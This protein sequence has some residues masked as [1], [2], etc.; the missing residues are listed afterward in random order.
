MSDEPAHP[1]HRQATPRNWNS[2]WY[3][4]RQDIVRTHTGATISYTYQDHPGAVLVVPVTPDRQVVLLRQYRYLTGGW[5]WEAPAGGMHA[6]ETAANCAAREL[7]EETGY[8]AARIDLLTSVY[9]SKSVSNERLD[10]FLAT[11]VTP[12]PGALRHEPSELMSVVVL[13]L[14]EAVGLV[15]QHQIADMQTALALLLAAARLE[16]GEPAVEPAAGEAPSA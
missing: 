16:Q 14:A 5:G 2:R 7:A 11:G 10:L 8:T 6:G 12:E 15:Y 3:D 13:P 9:P 4:L 1:W